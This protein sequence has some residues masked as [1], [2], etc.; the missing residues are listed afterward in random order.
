MALVPFL[1]RTEYVMLAIF[2]ALGLRLLERLRSRTLLQWRL[3]AG[4]LPLALFL[5]AGVLQALLLGSNGGTWPVLALWA[6]ALALVLLGADAVNRVAD[7]SAVLLPVGLGGAVAAVH[8]I[9]QSF[10][11]VANE[12][13]WTDAAQGDWT[14]VFSVFGNPNIFGTYLA[15]L[16]PL[17]LL[18]VYVDRRWWKGLLALPVLGALVLTYS[19]GAW[20]ACAVGI[21]LPLIYLSRRWLWVM[22]GGAVVA[23]FLLPRQIWSRIMS[24]SL[25]DSSINYRLRIFTGA[26]GAIREHFWFGTGAGLVSFREAYDRHQVAQTPAFHA[27]NVFLQTWAE[28]GLL[29]LMLLLAAFVL[30]AFD[31]V[32]S[33]APRPERVLG[34]A[35]AGSVAGA[36]LQGL[37]DYIWTDF[38]VALLFWL[39]VGVGLGLLRAQEIRVTSSTS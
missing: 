16:A 28:R 25:N 33:R 32:R 2:G 20:A 23:P 12:A 4:A 37:V 26:W 6:T 30:F 9:Y 13:R 35:A 1:P 14:R 8:G 27:H 21:A 11:G 19:R 18:L 29:G 31:L 36:L 38:R 3:P 39:V 5:G 34:I 24:I 7:A 22:A 10:A 15:L 17:L